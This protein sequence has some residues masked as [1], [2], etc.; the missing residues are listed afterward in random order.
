MDIQSLDG[1]ARF[2]AEKMQ[3]VNL[4]KTDHFFLDLYCLEPGQSQKVHR[5]DDSSKFYLVV[6]GEARMHVDGEE[7][8]L[9]PRQLVAAPAGKDHGVTNDSNERTVILVV[10][11]PPP[12]HASRSK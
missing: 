8:S 5:H 7:A 6:E 4:L 10:M 9:E 3:K 2:A 1:A 12:E 11:A